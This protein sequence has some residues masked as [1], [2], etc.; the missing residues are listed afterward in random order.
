MEERET[1]QMTFHQ[2]YTACARRGLA[3]SIHQ[4]DCGE[5]V[6]VRNGVGELFSVSKDCGADPNA[7]ATAATWLITNGYIKYSDAP[8]PRADTD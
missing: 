2:L 6:R 4:W 8:S 5:T 3:A 1:V 7:V